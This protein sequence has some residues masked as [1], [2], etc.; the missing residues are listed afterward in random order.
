[1]P[2]SLFDAGEPL[3]LALP[4]VPRVPEVRRLHRLA[5]L[6]DSS[7]ALSLLRGM[8]SEPVPH[9]GSLARRRRGVLAGPVLFPRR[10]LSHPPPASP[11]D[12][13]HLNRSWS[14][15]RRLQIASPGKV[16]FCVRRKVR[17]SVLFAKGIGGR[18][19]SAPGRGGSYYRRQE[20]A[21]SC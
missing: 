11:F 6:S 1:M 15:F 19:H 8:G 2:R 7:D 5:L 9:V 21:W 13:H 18:R 14:E 16:D 17:R 4:E 10:R 12:L 20:S 3:S